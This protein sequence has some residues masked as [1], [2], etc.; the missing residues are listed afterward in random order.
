M[1]LFILFV[2]GVWLGRIVGKLEGKID[3]RKAEKVYHLTP[4]APTL[5]HER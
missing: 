2:L 5:Q 4:K 1:E 3:A